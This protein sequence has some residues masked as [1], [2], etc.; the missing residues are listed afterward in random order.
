MTKT[1]MLKITHMI[2]V[3]ALTV[4]GGGFSALAQ[5]AK[6][7]P[8]LDAIPRTSGR[9]KCTSCEKL[10]QKAKEKLEAAK[11]EQGSDSLQYALASV[12][13][14]KV[15]FMQHR[16]HE[17]DALLQNAVKIQRAKAPDSQGL[18][19]TLLVMMQVYSEL[20]P[21]EVPKLAEEAIP[22]ME[23][24]LARDPNNLALVDDLKQLYVT[25]G[26]L[27]HA[28]DL[29]ARGVKLARA[30]NEPP[31]L[32]ARR[33]ETYSLLLRDDSLLPRAESA[34]K[35]AIALRAKTNANL[36]MLEWNRTTLACVLLG[37]K[38]YAAA[39]NLLVEEASRAKARKSCSEALCRTMEMVAARIEK[40]KPANAAKMTK[41]LND[42]AKS[43][44]PYCKS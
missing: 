32:L 16:H 18:A 43:L 9:A 39:T 3:T 36:S 33:L 38:K 2:L 35:E 37:E 26:D 19:K 40:T 44:A 5:D 28:R 24:N 34:L 10:E 31:D 23:S 15:Y 27:P 6:T 22:L 4:T 17:A 12:D 41:Q 13:V 11:K 20:K 42:A 7:M 30:Q 25:Q 21:A 1:S 14:A 29:S 8:R